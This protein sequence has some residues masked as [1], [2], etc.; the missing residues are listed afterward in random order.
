MRGRRFIAFAV[1][2]GAVLGFALPAANGADGAG[3]LRAQADS[4][5]ARNATLADRRHSALLELYALESRAAQAR[6]RA[7]G[8]RARLAEVRAE[9]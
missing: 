4:L 5:R 9:R 2:A 3:S 6:A 7:T 8:L 1:A